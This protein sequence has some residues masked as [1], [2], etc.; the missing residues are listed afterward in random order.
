MTKSKT[1]DPSVSSP[2]QE[3]FPDLDD[4]GLAARLRQ[5]VHTIRSWRSRNPEKLPP[6]VQVGRVWLYDKKI[7]DEWLAAKRLAR[8][9]ATPA[10]P[11]SR[12][13]PSHRRRGKPSKAEVTAAEKS[14]LTV[15]AWR[16]LQA[17][18]RAPTRG[19]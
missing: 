9:P 18:L 6:G 12:D 1:I 14:G 15:P 11:E 10:S 5:S 16:E 8:T 19:Q 7:T 17:S 2:V 3:E 13:Q 4:E